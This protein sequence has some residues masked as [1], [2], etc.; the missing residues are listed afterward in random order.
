M[1]SEPITAIGEIMQLAFV[2]ADMDAALHYWTQTIGAGPFVA[3]DHIQTET[4]AYYGVPSAI[5]FSLYLGYWGEMQIELIVQHNDAP[6]IYKTW[7]D[8]GRDGLHHVCVLTQDMPRARAIMRAAESPI[9]QELT[10][11]G[12]VEA[13]YAQM[14]NG[15]GTLVE[16][17]KP[18]QLINDSFAYIKGLSVGWDGAE[19]VRRLG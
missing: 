1:R 19:P 17:L 12:G 11:A 18:N 7:R 15:P 14:G 13:F 9:A 10:M 4:C 6:S 8:E 5:D 3:L 16:V 2:P